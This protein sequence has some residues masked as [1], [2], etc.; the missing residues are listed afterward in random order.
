MARKFQELIDK[1]P[2]DSQARIKAR[3]DKLNAEMPLHELRAALDLTQEQLADN[4]G[5]NQAAV[6]KMERRTDM[7]VSTLSSI[8]RGMGGSLEI[9]AVMPAGKVRITQFRQAH[10]SPEKLPKAAKARLADPPV[11]RP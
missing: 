2:P 11:S 8:I 1:M 10:R 4:L 3:I 7:Y 9:Y 6:S 5:V